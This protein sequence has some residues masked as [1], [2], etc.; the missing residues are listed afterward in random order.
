MPILTEAALGERTRRS[1]LIALLAVPGV[2]VLLLVFVLAWGWF[3]P[4]YL[5]FGGAK[6]I[7]VGRYVSEPVVPGGEYLDWNAGCLV[8]PLPGD[9]ESS[10]YN[11]VLM[12]VVG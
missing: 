11:Y 7:R 8:F 9:S 5:D 12:W 1:W 2:G 6:G 4:T 3:H 10:S